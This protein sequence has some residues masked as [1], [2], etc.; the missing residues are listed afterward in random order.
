MALTRAVEWDRCPA[1][2][3]SFSAETVS[4]RLYSAS[5]VNG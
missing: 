5:T 3:G 4:F 2:R 1:P